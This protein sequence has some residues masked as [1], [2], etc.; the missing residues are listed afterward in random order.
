MSSESALVERMSNAVRSAYKAMEILK[1]ENRVLKLEN[2]EL[3]RQLQ[4]AAGTS[5][6]AGTRNH[7][8]ITQT[9]SSPNRYS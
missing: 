3:K 8:Q 4:L 5:G 9:M 7:V 6:H 2:E 1:E